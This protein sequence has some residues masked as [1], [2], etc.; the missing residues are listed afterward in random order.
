MS[1]NAFAHIYSLGSNVRSFFNDLPLGSRSIFCD[2]DGSIR[3]RL[4]G[5]LQP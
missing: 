2:L 4:Y 5:A 3:R 1:E